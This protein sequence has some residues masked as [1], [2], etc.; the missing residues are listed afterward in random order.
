MRSVFGITEAA[1]ELGCSIRWLRDAEKKGKIPNAQR[2][3]NNWRVYTIEDLT[4]LRKLIA[5]G[6]KS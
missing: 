5:P 1:K 6:K 3:L 4:R 2:D